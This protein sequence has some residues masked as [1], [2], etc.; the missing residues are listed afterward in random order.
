MEHLIFRPILTG[1]LVTLKPMKAE[2]WDGM[3]K[4]A[5]NPATWADHVKRDR[6]KEAVFRRFFDEGLSSGT[7]FS[8]FNNQTQTIIGSSRYHDYKAKK[9]E[10]EIGWTFIDCAYWGGK[11]NKEIKRLMLQHIFHFLDVV[12]F[13]VAKENLRSQ[14]AMRKIGGKLQDGVYS[15]TDNGKQVP[16]VVFEIMKDDFFRGPL[17]DQLSG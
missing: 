13:W 12:V 10:I 5:S 9:S 15:K 4:A 14:A 2:D 3:Y 8:I 6:F 7:A 17:N 1:A 16:Y 11:Y